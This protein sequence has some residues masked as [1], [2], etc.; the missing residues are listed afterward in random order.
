MHPHHPPAAG[1]RPPALG[2][3]PSGLQG[4][5]SPAKRTTGSNIYG[6]YGIYGI[7]ALCAARADYSDPGAP[8]KRT[9]GCAR[10]FG[11]STGGPCGAH[12]DLTSAPCLTGA[13]AILKKLACVSPSRTGFMRYPAT[14]LSLGQAPRGTRSQL[15]FESVLF[16]L[17]T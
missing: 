1:R 11:C 4:V 9:I 14:S 2:S 17:F 7:Y 10:G 8:G 5:L 15:D 16:Y 13:E 12:M 6:I 3:A